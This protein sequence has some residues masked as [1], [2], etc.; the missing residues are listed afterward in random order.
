MAVAPTLL[1]LRGASRP[2]D[3]G[4][5]GPRRRS[6]AGARDRLLPVVFG[7]ERTSGC[8]LDTCPGSRRIP[9]RASDPVGQT[10]RFPLLLHVAARP[11]SAPK[12]FPSGGL[13]PAH[14]RTRTRCWLR[15]WRLCPA[16]VGHACTSPGLPYTRWPPALPA[17]SGFTSTHPPAGPDLVQPRGGGSS[18]GQN[19]ALTQ[20]RVQVQP[21]TSSRNSDVASHPLGTFWLSST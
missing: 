20:A 10:V 2:A 7:A 16:H 4:V 5:R 1:C 3:G 8:V 17:S 12:P 19:A 14:I 13:C 9:R 18:L 11:G 21:Q 6:P 15:S